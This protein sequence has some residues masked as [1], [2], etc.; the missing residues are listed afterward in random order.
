MFLQIAVRGHDD[1]EVHVD[2]LRAAHAFEAFFFQHT[3]QFRLNRQRQLANFVQKQRSP[4]RQIHLSHFARGRSRIC[5]LFM[6]EQLVFHQPFR[7]RRTIQRHER[8][9]PS[10]REM[11]N[12]QRKQFLS[13]AAFA[14]QQAGGV[15]RRDF[16]DLLADLADRLMFSHDPREAVAHRVLRT[17]QQILAL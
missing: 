5:A 6:T 7:N 15:R 16:L 17:Q 1:T 10:R 4:M 8:L 2:R 12:R 11:M 13:R 9:L 3:Q 14:Q